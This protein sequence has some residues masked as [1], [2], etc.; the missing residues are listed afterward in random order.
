MKYHIWT[1]G[2][3][4]NVAD[5]R[6]LASALEQ[7]G[8]EPTPKPDQADVIVLNT[9]V[10]RQSAENKAIGRL[11]SLR[12][13]KDKNPDLV[14]NLMGCLIGVRGNTQIQSRFPWVDVVSPPS[15]PEP[16]LNLLNERAGK[17]DVQ[18]NVV[19]TNA[20][21]D[22]DLVLPKSEQGKLV[23]AYIP[24]VYGC[25]H[26]CTY[27]IIPAKRGWEHSRP[28]QEILQE[29][30]SLARQGVKEITLL[31]QIVDRYGLDL[32]EKPTLATLLRDLSEIEDLKRIRFLTSHPNWMTDDLLDAVAELP[33]VCPHIEVPI[34]AGDDEILHA[35]RRGYTAQAYRDL[36][37]RIRERIPGVS[38]ATDIIVGF[39][40]ETD[41][42]F[43]ETYRLLD[44]L[45]MDVAHLARY[46]PR[47]GTYSARKL[48]DDVPEEEKMRRFR[49]L[50]DLQEEISA[51]INARCL[52][53][54]VP[55]LF[56]EKSRGRWRGRTPTNKLVFV[57]TDQDLLGQE[58][59]VHITWTGP[60][61]M[62]GELT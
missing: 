8:Y 38:I 24:I 29:A 37:G 50:E 11:S 15:D 7:M 34:Q 22:G 23:S 16:L 31:G 54:D 30:H 3:Q 33:K 4:M 6:R 27:C 21:L 59:D 44:D 61:S 48:A 55:V 13:L 26:A 14:I 40:G 47:E 41:E 45:R 57:E 58:R 35:M 9:C 62:I 17:A 25:S 20:V 39:P 5:S 42:Q 18:A 2:C 36:I 56:E 1:E 32:P 51:E 43:Q 52:D 53:A 12:P 10:V 28:Y 49:L 60:W 19:K 46:S